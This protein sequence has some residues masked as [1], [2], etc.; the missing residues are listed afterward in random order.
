MREVTRGRKVGRTP[1]RID[2]PGRT[3]VGNS[4]GKARES[5]PTIPHDQP[6]ASSGINDN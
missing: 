3:M 2:Q 4:S 5:L 6:R 1:E